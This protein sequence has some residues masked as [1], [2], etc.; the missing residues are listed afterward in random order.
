VALVIEQ[1]IF[2]GRFQPPHRDHVALAVRMAQELGPYWLGVVVHA[3]APIVEA[4][5]GGAAAGLTALDVDFAASAAEHHDA[6]RNPLSFAQRHALWTSL[7][8][9][10]LPPGRRPRVIALPRPE[11]GW[12][13]IEAV[14][15][16]P[17]AWIV[18]DGGDAFDDDKAD[19][20]RRRRDRVVRP[21]YRP[22]T[23]GRR[24][25][26]LLA[27][28]SPEIGAHVDT[29]VAALL[30]LLAAGKDIA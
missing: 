28:G 1:L 4:D 5:I 3:P 7:L 15:P 17:R 21:C 11:L 26:A 18:P 6:E 10:R 27:S 19:F 2:P 25:R 14:L 16:G 22:V 20:F 9:R 24:V 13:W 29:E 8:R 12:P 23:D 30:A